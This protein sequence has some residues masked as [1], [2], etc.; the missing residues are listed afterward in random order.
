MEVTSSAKSKCADLYEGIKQAG[1]RREELRSQLPFFTPPGLFSSSVQSISAL[2]DHGGHCYQVEGLLAR[3][4]FLE[5]E[6]DRH[7]RML[8]VRVQLATP[9]YYYENMKLAR[10]AKHDAERRAEQL[11][12]RM[13][14]LNQEN[15]EA[16]LLLIAEEEELDKLK[17][18]LEDVTRALEKVKKQRAA[19]IDS[20]N[21]K[22]VEQLKAVW[23]Q[24][25]K[26]SEKLKA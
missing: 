10:E 18:E 19:A 26:D 13:Y 9:E 17:T 15:S 21:K 5:A 4:Q 12:E 23:V 3:S 20:Y 22:T 24:L 11:R 6:L 7:P 2:I 25:D 14:R 16:I 8:Q 1:A